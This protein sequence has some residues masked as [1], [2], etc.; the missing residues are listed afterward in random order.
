VAFL[1]KVQAPG[2]AEGLVS[3]AK[4]CPKDT[5]GSKQ[6]SALHKLAQANGKGEKTQGGRKGSETVLQGRAGER[7]RERGMERTVQCACA[8]PHC[9]AQAHTGT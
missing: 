4:I 9:V 6:L 5:A 3:T 1:S 8:G 7:K 2:W